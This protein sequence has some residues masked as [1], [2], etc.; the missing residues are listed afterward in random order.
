[1]NVYCV[2]CLEHLSG[3]VARSVPKVLGIYKTEA[4]TYNQKSN[5]IVDI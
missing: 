3:I 5:L 4:E 2:I 1:M